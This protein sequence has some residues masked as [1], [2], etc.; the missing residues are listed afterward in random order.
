VQR[1]TRIGRI[2]DNEI[3]FQKDGPV[4]RHHATIELIDGAYVLKEVMSSEPGQ[5]AKAP[6]YGTFLNGARVFQPVK[7]SS[8]DEIQLGK[9]LRLRFEAPQEFQAGGSG[10]DKTFDEIITDQPTSDEL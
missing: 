10:G 4:S 6:T 2:E 7:L 5:P 9:R 8:K 3:V 1:V